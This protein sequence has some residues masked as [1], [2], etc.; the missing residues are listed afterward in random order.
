MRMS[1]LISCADRS[2]FIR[3]SVCNER[4]RRR[5]QHTRFNHRLSPPES[6]M[7]TANKEVAEKCLS[8]AQAAFRKGCFKEALRLA[9]MSSRS[10]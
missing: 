1:P 4:I 8:K 2:L 6:Y 9:E 10:Y 3:S 7:E 5:G